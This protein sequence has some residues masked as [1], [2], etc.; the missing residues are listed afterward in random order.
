MGTNFQ[1]EYDGI[2]TKIETSDQLINLSGK[3]FPDSLMKGAKDTFL[4]D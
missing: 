2:Y 3:V 1:N 4:I